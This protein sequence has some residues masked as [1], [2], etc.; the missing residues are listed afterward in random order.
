M[1]ERTNGLSKRRGLLTET[2]VLA[3][4]V[5]TLTRAGRVEAAHGSPDA[6]TALHVGVTNSGTQTTTLTTTLGTPTRPG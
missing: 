5:A 6:T 3:S 2:A 1:G 4:G